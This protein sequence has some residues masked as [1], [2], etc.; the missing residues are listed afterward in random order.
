MMRCRITYRKTAPLRYTGNL[1]IQKI[2]ER[3]LRRAGLP[4]A[5]SQGFH[6][7]PRI[8]QACPLPLG[9][10][11]QAELA[12][13]Y[14]D[15][16]TLRPDDITRSLQAMP[17]PGIEIAAVEEID[18]T[19]ATLAGRVIATEYLAEWI[20]PLDADQLTSKASALLNAPQ[21]LRSRRDRNYDLRPLIEAL[22]VLPADSSHNAMLRMQLSARQSATGRP[23]EV[24]SALG[25]APYDARFTRTRIM[26]TP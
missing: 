15:N 4:V 10:L 8:Q 3:Y 20:D 23:E 25:Y 2:W 14:L 6:P 17:Y 16:D 19:E 21:L 12:D 22:E 11:S 9:F 5:Y 13:I 18:L 7:Q 1:D 26:F 24:V